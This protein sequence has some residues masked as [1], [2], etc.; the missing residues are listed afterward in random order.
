MLI[1]VLLK[2]CVSVI[3]KVSSTNGHHSSYAEWVPVGV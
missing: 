3:M 2:E 1:L